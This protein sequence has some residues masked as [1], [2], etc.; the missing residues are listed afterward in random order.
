[1][2]AC[3]PLRWKCGP[4]KK[5]LC[6][7]IEFYAVRPPFCSKETEGNLKRRRYSGE[8]PYAW[9]ALW[10]LYLCRTWVPLAFEGSL[11]SYLVALVECLLT[12][13]VCS[14]DLTASSFQKLPIVRYPLWSVIW[15]NVTK[16]KMNTWEPF[17]VLCIVT[18]YGQ[19]CSSQHPI[20]MHN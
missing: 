6:Y 15:R 3:M 9:V 8:I 5:F 4:T 18:N 12:E 11:D 16:R 20:D 7:G 10:H 17:D 19:C 1:M 2:F 14:P 13:P